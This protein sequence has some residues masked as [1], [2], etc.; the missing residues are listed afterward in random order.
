MSIL[1]V[2][3]KPLCLLVVAPLFAHF[4]VTATPRLRIDEGSGIIMV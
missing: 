3:I 4:C 1:S 2:A